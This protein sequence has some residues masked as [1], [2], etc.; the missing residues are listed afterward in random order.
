M[1]QK[2]HKVFKTLWVYIP[3]KDA[4]IDDAFDNYNDWP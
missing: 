4:Q 2:T 1:P 3:K